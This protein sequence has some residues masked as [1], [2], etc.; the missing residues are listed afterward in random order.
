MDRNI[1]FLD[2]ISFFITVERVANPSLRGKPVVISPGESRSL[3]LAASAEAHGDGVTRGMS[4]SRSRRLCPGVTVIPPN[5]SL[6]R[7][8]SRAVFDT[9]ARFTPVI[10]PVGPGHA[11]LDMTGTGR[12][13]G[14][15]PDIARTLRREIKARL[16]LESTVGLAPNKLLSNAAA[17]FIK[18]EDI[19]AI[20]AGEEE[21][22]LAPLPVTFIPELR[23][24]PAGKPV[25]RR[26]REINLLRLGEVAVFPSPLLIT[27]FGEFGCMLSERSRGI[28]PRPVRPPEQGR[29]LR[30]ADTLPEDT[31]DRA[32]LASRLRV[33]A[34]R[35]GSSLRRR[36]I[37]AGRISLSLRYSDHRETRRNRR[38]NPPADSDLS[39]FESGRELLEKS[40]S[41]RTRISSLDITLSSLCT[42]GRQLELFT[43]PRSRSLERAIDRIRESFG[44]H[45]IRHGL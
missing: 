15:P 6:Y 19:F 1:F 22:F 3:V 42:G 25:L 31:N 35:A 27:L 44:E 8:A 11:Y 21:R 43:P 40:L 14:P 45:A 38:L 4:L 37:R 30:F 41:R 26:L 34:S 39:L 28:D 2:V 29:E 18:P 33:L 16:R 36:N 24:D 9:L 5:D 32:L 12:L 10:E 23:E 20:R 7:R 17:H 13:L